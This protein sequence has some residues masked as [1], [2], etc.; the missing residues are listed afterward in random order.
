MTLKDLLANKEI[1]GRLKNLRF[2][3]FVY[4]IVFIGAIATLFKLSYPNLFAPTTASAET[5]YDVKDV[6]IKTLEFKVDEINKKV[7]KLDD[8]VD[9]IIFYQR[10][11]GNGR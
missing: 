1:Y 10:R 7:D 9:K 2:V 3:D 6:A 11:N 8:K 5:R 4:A